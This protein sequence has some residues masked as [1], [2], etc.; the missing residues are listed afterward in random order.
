MINELDFKRR[1]DNY[2]NT[3][4]RKEFV[5]NIDKHKSSDGTE[6]LTTSFSI[7]DGSGTHTLT[8]KN[9]LLTAYTLV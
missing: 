1:Q 2:K 7:T 5:M 3:V 9:G 8:F 6:G 4:L